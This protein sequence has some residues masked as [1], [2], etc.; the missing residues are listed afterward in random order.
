MSNINKMFEARVERVGEYTKINISNIKAI[1]KV[2]YVNIALLFALMLLMVNGPSFENNENMYLISTYA[3]LLI[4]VISNIVFN[5]LFYKGYDKII[6]KII[7]DSI[8]LILCFSVYVLSI[9]F[10]MSDINLAFLPLI[11][12]AILITPIAYE[13]QIIIQDSKYLQ[14]VDHNVEKSSI[15][16]DKCGLFRGKKALINKHK[17]DSDYGLLISKITVIILGLL[18]WL[19]GYIIVMSYSGNG[20][21]IGDNKSLFIITTSTIGISILLLLFAYN[22]MLYGNYKGLFR[23]QVIDALL[24][25]INLCIYIIGTYIWYFNTSEGIEFFP[26][27]VAGILQLPLAYEFILVLTTKSE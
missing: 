18:V 9:Y 13:F 24:I 21:V 27:M 7:T 22:K 25:G 8:L 5:S 23:K 6:S 3:L 20:P 2:V 16:S 19:T 17:N 1:K 11:I 10:W 14:L 4:V 26:L 15:N 12:W